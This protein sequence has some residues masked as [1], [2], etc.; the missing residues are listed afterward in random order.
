MG[1]VLKQHNLEAYEKVVKGL[2]VKNKVA[3]VEP[4]GTGKSFVALKWIE[5]YKQKQTLLLVPSYSIIL[6]YEEHMK[7]CGYERKD[8]HNLE[9]MTYSTLMSQVKNGVTPEVEHIILD[10]FH[11]CG[12]PEWRKGVNGLL[13]KNKDAKV[14]GLSAT[15]IRYLDNQRD[16]S[17]ELFDGNV[18]F[19]MDLTEAVARGILKFPLYVTGIYNLDSDIKRYEK[20]IGEVTDASL[21]KVLTEKLKLARRN[22]ACAT[23]LEDIFFK[24][25]KTKDGK[26]ILFCK[27][28]IHMEQMIAEASKWF[29]KVNS[30]IDIYSIHFEKKDNEEKLLEFYNSNNSHL[31][32]LF[33]IDMLN[34]GFHAP[35]IDGIVMLRPTIS[36]NLF[37]QQLGRGLA[38]DNQEIIIYDIVNNVRA[39][40]DIKDF[41][42]AVQKKREQLI[43]ENK[44][45]ESKTIES[46]EIL[47]EVRELF[48]TLND[49]EHMLQTH[50]SI[51]HKVELIE[52]F[53]QENGRLPF[54]RETY[55]GIA[56]G[57]FLTCI[58]RGT[59]N[60]S[61]ALLERLTALGFENK[62]E[63]KQAKREELI[64]LTEE[65]YQINGRLPKAKE[66]YKG[67]MLGQFLIRIKI[68]K[69]VITENQMKRLINIGF[70]PKT[71]DKEAEKEKK[72]TLVEEFYQINGRL[73]KY[74]EVY[75]DES[76]GKFLNNVRRKVTKISDDLLKRLLAIGFIPETKNSEEEKERKVKLIE[77]FYEEYGR[78]P[79]YADNY[80]EELIGQFLNRIKIGNVQI[81][82][83]Q[84]K[85]LMTIG[86]IP[87]AKNKEEEKE[88]K[89][90]LIEEFYKE[91]GRL[92]KSSE[93][94]K[95]EAIGIFLKSIRVGDT[96]VSEDQASRLAALGF[97][98]P[99]KDRQSERKVKKI[100]RFYQERG[101]LPLP[102]ES[103]YKEKIKTGDILLSIQI[104]E[105]RITESQFVRLQK[106][107]VVLNKEQVTF[108]EKAPVYVKK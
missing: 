14:L 96:G 1:V 70:E 61:N 68:Q 69:I 91:N 100:E 77:E 33:C 23:K 74:A 86:F 40:M 82:K 6:Q 34:E 27:D 65:F 89:I 97:L 44:I 49:I 19:R 29:S 62:I 25:M 60:I 21:K 101:R 13:E 79:K 83:M 59:T 93:T 80:K 17:D 98:G 78:L 4:P 84:M 63:D 72:V 51:E 103:L 108:F 43:K 87:E 7:A 2:K 99:I 41:L 24:H 42:K 76:I 50:T 36:P 5:E 48:D 26:I 22:L 46:F 55:G 57:L 88:R 45:E 64:K 56:I 37:I 32:L 52:E 73:P 11:R 16:M 31:K 107:G 8:F 66:K 94:Y 105:I 71:K 30:E 12:A 104:G 67:E 47:E 54:Q 3:V 102:G 20:K 15:P 10:E 92:P 90:K 53:Y 75:K 28:K 9:I 39:S 81:T 18:V 95:N 58:K 85:R 106:I 35:K 38:L